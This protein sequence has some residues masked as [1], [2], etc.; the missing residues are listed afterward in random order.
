MDTIETWREQRRWGFDAPLAALKDHPLRQQ[1]ESELAL[2]TPS[3][4]ALDEFEKLESVENLE[5]GEFVVS[6]SNR[7]GALTRLFDSLTEREWCDERHPIGR[8]QYDVYNSSD[9]DAWG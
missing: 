8:M 4:P 5:F 7:T 3:L 1:I 2:L 9:Y 6:L